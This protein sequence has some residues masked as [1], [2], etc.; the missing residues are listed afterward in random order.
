MK[1]KLK[2]AALVANGLLMCL[3]FALS[4]SL[5]VRVDSSLGP[6]YTLSRWL[7][8]ENTLSQVQ[9]Q[10]SDPAAYPF[11]VSAFQNGGLYYAYTQQPVSAVYGLLRPTLEEALGSMV[12]KKPVQREDY[13]RLLQTGEGFLLEYDGQIPLAAMRFWSGVSPGEEER[14]FGRL[15]LLAQEGRVDLLLEGESGA[16]HR[17]ATAAS[18]EKLRAALEKCGPD[19]SFFAAE[20]PSLGALAADQP[21]PS[22]AVRLPVY[23]CKAAEAVAA[24]VGGGEMPRTLLEC[25]SMNPYL[26]KR[27]AAG[28]EMAVFVQGNYS[29]RLGSDGKA[30]FTVDGG[31]GLEGDGGDESLVALVSRGWQ[32][33]QGALDSVGSPLALSLKSIQPGQGEGEYTILFS[34]RAQGV[35][36][37]SQGVAV[38]VR[39]GVIVSV[40]MHLLALTQTGERTLLPYPLAAAAMEGEGP[41]RLQCRYALQEGKLTPYL[42][43]AAEKEG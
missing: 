43:Y 5:G 22:G 33:A 8:G 37:T 35:S 36:L 18:D 38:Q 27:Y 29:L 16:W 3:L 4:V 39:S 7:R 26:A 17:F 14:N 21:V 2:T 19:G 24:A 20:D 42:S 31:E 30:Q 15:M 40:E 6:F 11:A 10:E 13:I 23:E 32:T 9:Q 28:E 25:F 34:S 41:V 12:E 1:E